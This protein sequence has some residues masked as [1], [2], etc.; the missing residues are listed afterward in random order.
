[1]RNEPNYYIRI[2]ENALIQLC[3]SGL[4]AYCVPHGRNLKKANELETYGLLLGHEVHLPRNDVLYSVDMV[5][6]DTSTVRNTGSCY[7]KEESISL[8][9]DILTSFWPQ[10][11]CLGDFHT[12]PYKDIHEVESI[13][14]YDF[15]EEDYLHIEG[16]S[17]Y[18]IEHKYRVGIAVTIC[19][20]KRRGTKPAEAIR[21]SA[22]VFTLNRYR[23][24]ISAYVAKKDD[25]GNLRISAHDDERVFLDC[26]SAFA[27]AEEYSRFGKPVREKGRIK[28]IPGEI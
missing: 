3:L 8:K 21:N 6:V 27:V 24:W 25:K 13:E 11:E 19:E 26:P 4:E 23:I 22:I 12:H 10:Y 7:P 9:R 28:H 16:N 5:T 18:W 17:D 2:S 14:G 20:L 1:M 15:S